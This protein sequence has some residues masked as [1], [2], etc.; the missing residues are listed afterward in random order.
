VAKKKPAPAKVASIRHKDKR[1]NIPTDELR[2]FV[3]DDELAPKTML[4]P[5]RRFAAAAPALS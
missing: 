2:D 3:T 1:K 4:H 5:R